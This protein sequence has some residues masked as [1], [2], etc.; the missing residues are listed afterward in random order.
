MITR[1]TFTI[2]V[3]LG[4]WSGGRLSYYQYKSGEACP[5][6]GEAIPACYIAFAGYIL[7]GIGA[8]LALSIGGSSGKYIFWTGIA[9]AGG[10]AAFATVFEL[11]KGNVCPVGFGGI[12]MCYLSLAM[13]VLIG[14]QF[15]SITHESP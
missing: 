1:I 14:L 6:L 10:L 3:L 2:M 11:I 7:I 13:S 4:L 8:S 12:P 9:I 5:I 15:W